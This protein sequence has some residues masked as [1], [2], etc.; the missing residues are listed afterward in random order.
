LSGYKPNA[1]LNSTQREKEIEDAYLLVQPNA[2]EDPP[3][4]LLPSGLDAV[5][6]FNCPIK[7]A[8]RRADGRR[9]DS[10]FDEQDQ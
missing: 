6:W 7:E 5:M 9:Y 10:G 3:K 1:E 8:L 2:K 4:M